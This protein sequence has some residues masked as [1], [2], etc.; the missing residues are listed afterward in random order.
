MKL[1]RNYIST[2][3]HRDGVYKG[4]REC[5]PAAVL[6]VGTPVFGCPRHLK[7]ECINAFPALFN[8]FLAFLSKGEY[9]VVKCLQTHP[10]E[11]AT[12]RWASQ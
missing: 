11:I 12:A 6:L 10:L 9:T 8:K 7:A 2:I 1:L 5:F 4:R 3:H